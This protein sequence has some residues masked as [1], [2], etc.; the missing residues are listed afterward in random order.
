MK[1]SYYRRNPSVC[2]D[3]FKMH[4]S[5]FGNWRKRDRDWR[6]HVR[7]YLMG[8]LYYTLLFE[9]QTLAH[10]YPAH[11]FQHYKVVLVYKRSEITEHSF[12]KS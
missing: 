9:V 2:R 12:E 11:T 3:V 10:R 4:P 1:E 8:L 5:L 6:L 7:Y